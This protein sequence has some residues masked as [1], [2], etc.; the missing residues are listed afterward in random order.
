MKLSLN[1]RHKAAWWPT[2]ALARRNGVGGMVTPNSLQVRRSALMRPPH[3]FHGIFDV[4]PLPGL[5]GVALVLA[6][7][8]I[9]RGLGDGPMA[10]LLEHLPCDRVNLH[11]RYHVV[12]P[13]FP[14]LRNRNDR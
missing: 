3:H 9:L 7:H 2:G 13:M 14:H 10:V 1:L 11:L 8:G 6:S 4:T 5:F 12:L